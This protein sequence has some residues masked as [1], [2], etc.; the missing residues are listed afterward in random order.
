MF[1]RYLSW[2]LAICTLVFAPYIIQGIAQY[3]ERLVGTFY[4]VS[5]FA[6]LIL[7]GVL[8]INELLDHYRI[9]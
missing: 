7:L 6:V 4:L 8:L 1:R 9:F 5:F 3:N 2:V